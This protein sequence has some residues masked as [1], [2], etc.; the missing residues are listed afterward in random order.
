MSYKDL[1]NRSARSLKNAKLRTLLTALAIAVGGFTLFLTLAAGNGVREYTSNLISSNFDPSELIVGRDA[2]ISNRGAPSDE[3]QEYD[4]TISSFQA[5]PGGGG[6][7]QVKQVTREDIEILKANPDVEQVRESFNLSIRYVT[8][9]GQKKYTG[10]AE[11]YNPAQKPEIAAGSI[12]ESGDIPKGTVLLPDVYIDNLGFSSNEDAIGQEIEIM[13]EQPFSLETLARLGETAGQDGSINI[14]DIDTDSFLPRNKKFIYTI[15]AV[16]K[17]PVT[18]LS[19]GTQPLLLS[20]ED[21]REIYTFTTEGTSN[22]DQFVFVNVKVNGGEDKETRDM[23]KAGLEEQGFYVQSSEDIQQT[24]T[25]FVDILQGAVF[26]LGLVT[27]VASVFGIINTQYISVL[28]RTREI[29]LIKAL[30]MSSRKVRTLFIF[31]AMWIGFIGGIIGILFAFLLGILINPL[32]T[33]QLNLGEGNYL[34]IFSSLQAL[35]LLLALMFVAALAGFF[36]AR[37]AAKLDPVEALRTE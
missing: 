4:P 24:V 26:A 34:I 17:R 13:A 1:I 11:A 9:E 25:Q 35:S 27:L 2:E 37:K 7:F 12:P 15:G 31:E 8:R 32:I 36:P 10:S 22:F 29:G 16:T 23:V 18:S 14:N 3:P 5:G 21:A 30:G 19:F 20:T 28:E 6:G 33:D